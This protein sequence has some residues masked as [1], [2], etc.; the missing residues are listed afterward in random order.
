MKNG[1]QSWHLLV[2]RFW[3]VIRSVGAEEY[4]TLQDAVRKKVTLSQVND[5]IGKL[6]KYIDI[7]TNIEGNE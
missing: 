4:R 1:F 2:I 5:I 7:A 6:N 3:A